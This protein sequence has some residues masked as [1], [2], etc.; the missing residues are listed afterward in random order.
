MKIYISIIF[1]IFVSCAINKDAAKTSVEEIKFGSGGGFTGRET[2]Y[3]LSSTGKLSEGEKVLKQIDLKTTKS[4]F[5]EA[6]KMK[7]YSFNEP[8]NIYYFIIIQSKD[9][10]N[11]IVWGSGSKPINKNVSDLYNQLMS[12][13]K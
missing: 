5:K 6:E 2:T 11:R 4:L 12:L 9:N 10:K 7:A 8:Q 13:I 3:I 1:A